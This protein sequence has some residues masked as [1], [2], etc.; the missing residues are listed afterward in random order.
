MPLD[1]TEMSERAYHILSARDVGLDMAK[2]ANLEPTSRAYGMNVVVMMDE[3]LASEVLA[4]RL[5]R[6][7]EERSSNATETR[8]KQE[9]NLE[10]H[11]D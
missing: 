7:V 1:P 9:G 6:A 11:Q 3:A 8:E 4:G 5:M 10:Q 2:D